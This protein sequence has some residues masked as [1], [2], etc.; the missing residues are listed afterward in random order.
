MIPNS[1]S[2]CGLAASPQRWRPRCVLAPPLLRAGR[3][4]HH[5]RQRQGQL[6]RRRPRRDRHRHQR[7]HAVL[8]HRRHRR[9]G[10]VRAAPAAGRQLQ[11][12]SHAQR[13]QELRPDRHRPRGRPQRPHRRD[14]SSP[15]TSPKSSSVV[16]DA[17]L[18]ETNTAAL[19]RTR[20][21]ERSPE[22]AAGQPRPLLA[23]EHHRRRHQQRQ[24]QL[25]R[26][27]R[28]AHDDQRIAEGAD[29]HAS[30]SS[31]MAATTPPACAAPATRRRIPKRSRSSASSPTATP[32]STAA[33]PAGVVDVVTKSGT[34]QFHGAA[35]EFFRNEKL[36]A[37]RWA[38]P[39]TTVG[40]RIRSTAT[41]TAPRSAGRI[42][43]DKTFFFAS[44]SGLRQEETYYRNTAVVPDRARAGRRLLAVGDQAARSADQRSRS[45][46]TSFPPTRFDAAAL[47]IQDATCPQ[48]NLPEQLLRSAAG[49]IRSRPTRGRS[50]SITTSRRRTSLA[51]Q[52]LLS[53]R[54]PTRSRCR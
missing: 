50:S 33:I 22:P 6:G 45:P 32:P 10:P 24:L 3:D 14:A 48:S 30:T 4:R 36:N 29:R 34:N 37:K 51:R 15:A 7:R 23:A 38:P 1:T 25:A 27:P 5:P 19:S 54:A 26:R 8:A 2:R 53:R 42:S 9:G 31:S 46:A 17:P 52:L 49:P 47:T 43:R 35:F 44:Y 20:R 21:P 16:A 40:A 13:L 11:G 18:V 28:A 39:G 12:R 41:S